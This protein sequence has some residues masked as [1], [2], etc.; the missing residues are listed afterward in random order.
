MAISIIEHTPLMTSKV[1]GAFQEVITVQEGF[2]AWFPR[3]TTPSLYVDIRTRRGTRKLAPDVV[4]FTEGK[5]TKM[6]K[7]TEDK[8]LPPFYELEYFF[9][10]D[11]VYMRALEFG[12]LNSPAA[13]KMIAKNALDNLVE[14]RNMIERS[15]RLQQAQ[16][17]QTGIIT[18]INGDNINFR[19]RAESMVDVTADGGV[20]WNNPTTATPLADIAKGGAFLRNI[21]TATGNALNLIARGSVIANLMATDEFKTLADFRHI[22]RLNVGMPQFSE[23]T[24]F[25]YNGQVAAGDFRVNLWSYDEMYED[26]NDQTQFYLDEENVVLLP[27]NFIGKTVFGGLYGMK[28]ATIAGTDTRIPAIQE[29]EFLIR[30][31][32]DDR[33]M[34]SGI[35]MS[36]APIVLPIT[37]DRVYTMKV[38][39]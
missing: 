35:K 5:P 4:R 36:S 22:E 30:P 32:H 34:S 1:V 16:V 33:T 14:Q 7:G 37:V 26:E 9:N 10:R 25:T 21:G 11:E 38:L 8:Y 23:S 20:Y 18:L 31:F 3:E 15:I 13:N 6:S 2:S 19:R 24:G 39:A 29:A 17:F 12:S 28:D 27:V